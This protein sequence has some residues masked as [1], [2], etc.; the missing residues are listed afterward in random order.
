MFLKLTSKAT[1]VRNL[2]VLVILRRL[3]FFEVG[4]NVGAP[5]L[6]KGRLVQDEAVQVKFGRDAGCGLA[7]PGGRVRV[8]VDPKGVGPEHVPGLELEQGEGLLGR[9]HERG[10]RGDPKLGAPL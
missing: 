8:G 4:D 3:V 2:K 6:L 7:R 10:V 1:S 5:D 9:G